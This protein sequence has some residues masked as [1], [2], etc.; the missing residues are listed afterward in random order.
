MSLFC[1]PMA[2]SLHPRS[3]CDG[4]LWRAEKETSTLSGPPETRKKGGESDVH[5]RQEASK[6]SRPETERRRVSRNLPQ[7]NDIG[8]Q[9][10]SVIFYT[11]PAQKKEAQEYIDEL[12]SSGKHEQSIV[13]ETKEL[14]RFYEAEEGHKDYY[15]KNPNQAYCQ[16]V[17]APKVEK[18]VNNYGSLLK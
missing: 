9:Y 7:G 14:K 2:S 18:I 17:I 16:V 1:P 12:N 5:S 11:S 10:K 4:Q 8:E 13:T 6:R 3:G 15:S